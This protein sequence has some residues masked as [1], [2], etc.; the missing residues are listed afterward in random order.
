MLDS[1]L[2]INDQEKKYVGNPHLV[3]QVENLLLVVINRFFDRAGE[4]LSFALSLLLL[5]LLLLLLGGLHLLFLLTLAFLLLEVLVLLDGD[6][7][8]LV[9]QSQHSLTR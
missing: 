2:S 8:L 5:L 3:Q 7:G 1:G 6:V 4:R 9:D